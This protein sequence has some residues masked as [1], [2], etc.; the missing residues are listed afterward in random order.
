M[1]EQ[2]EVL[3]KEL[4]YKCQCT[5]CGGVFYDENPE[6]STQTLIPDEGEQALEQFT[7][8]DGLF[9][10]CPDCQTDEFLIDL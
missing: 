9:W 3:E 6:S 7:D 2:A 10:G 5:Q 8:K 1:G 4:V